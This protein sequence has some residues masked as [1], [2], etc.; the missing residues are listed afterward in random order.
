MCLYTLYLTLHIWLIILFVTHAVTNVKAKY[1]HCS[2]ERI[3]QP[4]SISVLNEN[5]SIK[6]SNIFTYYSRVGAQGT[7]V[8]GSWN[9]TYNKDNWKIC[10]HFDHR[11]SGR[12]FNKI[13]V[14]FLNMRRQIHTHVNC[15]LNMNL[16][17]FVTD[18]TQLWTLCWCAFV[19]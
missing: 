17:A 2:K 16:T 3:W 18:H 6:L 7:F 19:S 12:A 11:C 15:I 1:T 8:P 14:I 13:T 9:Q 4:L 10:S 5:K